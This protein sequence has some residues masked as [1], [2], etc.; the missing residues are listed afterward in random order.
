MPFALAITRHNRKSFLIAE[1]ESK[2]TG[3]ELLWVDRGHSERLGLQAFIAD[4]FRKVY[5]ADI[6]DF[7]DVL[8]GYRGE[9]GEWLAALGYT[10]L[11]GRK[12]FLEQYLDAPV[13]QEIAMHVRTSARRADI[14]EVGNLAATH[15]GA[16]RALILGMTR[17]LYARR[18]RWV[19]F[20]AT[21]T[22][23]NS[24]LR[25]RL[26][27]VALA[28]ADPRRLPDQAKDWGSYYDSKPQ[29]MFGEIA[30]G[31]AQLVR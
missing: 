5:S 2:A 7:C 9:D 12:G 16:A 17:H 31:Y 13:E 22:L 11:D 29:V 24:F 15:A 26:N 19:T 3:A 4:T 30:Q 27:P 14:V 1:A 28:A 25:L 6:H 8:V 23:L 18:Y 21:R 20:T 10:P